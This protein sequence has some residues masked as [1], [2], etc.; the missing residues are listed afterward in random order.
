MV[1]AREVKRLQMDRKQQQEKAKAEAW[2]KDQ[3]N[4]ATEGMMLA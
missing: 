1:K 2:K 4:A 3:M